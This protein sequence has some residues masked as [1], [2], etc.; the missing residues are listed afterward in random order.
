MACLGRTTIPK[1][2][3][4]LQNP[5]TLGLT[6]LIQ[7]CLER[8]VISIDTAL[9]HLCAALGHAADLLLPRSRR[10]LGRT[11]PTTTLLWPIPN[12]SPFKSIRLLVVPYGFTLLRM[13]TH[14][15]SYQAVKVRTPVLY[16]QPRCMGHYWLEKSKC[17]SNPQRSS[18]FQR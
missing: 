12:V 8:R 5:A 14:F 2:G 1:L 17:F 18:T 4:D 15:V 13:E 3:I 10:T 6:G 9:I 11:S 16:L 7:L